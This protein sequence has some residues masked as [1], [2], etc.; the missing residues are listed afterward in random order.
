[1]LADYYREQ[2]FQV[3]H[4]GTGAAGSRYDGGID[5][6]LRRG[7]EY[8]IVE[9]KHWNAL[10]VP[11]NVVHQ[12]M[13]IMVNESAT[14]AILVTSGEFTPYAKEAANKLGHVQL[15]DG[16]ALRQM[17]GPEIAATDGVE[18]AL[19]DWAP[20]A[21]RS[22]RPGNDKHWGVIAAIVVT[23]ALL[24]FAVAKLKSSVEQGGR[25]ASRVTTAS[26]A[27]SVPQPQPQQPG[28]PLDPLRTAGRFVAM[29]GAALTGDQRALQSQAQAFGEDIRKSMKMADPT[30]RINQEAA[31]ASAR[32]V[33]GVRSVN[34]VDRENLFAIVSRNDQRSYATIDAICAQLEPLGDTLGVIVNLQSAAARNGAELE[35]LSR[36]CRLRPG[37]R[38]FAQANR[39][40]DVLAPDDR[41]RYEA[42][43]V[44]M[45]KEDLKKQQESM[46]ALEA[47]TKPMEW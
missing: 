23:L 28:E 20:I 6:K 33:P 34:W 14:G 18:A 24:W 1:M 2:G 32:R 41:A 3:E 10:Q 4:C 45:S 17:L 38:A 19:S 42:G 30:R 25:A 47:N 21:R 5:L 8:V 26:P 29:Q 39:R 16:Q 22:S 11:H 12:L 46:K 9:C 31:R 15:V 44:E 27:R 43:R 35:I 37:E 40:M 13:G 36:N 7:D